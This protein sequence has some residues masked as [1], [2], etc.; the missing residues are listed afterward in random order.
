MTGRYHVGTWVI[1]EDA[2]GKRSRV[3][4]IGKACAMFYRETGNDPELCDMLAFLTEKQEVAFKTARRWWIIAADSVWRCYRR[5]EGND[6]KEARILY[7][8]DRR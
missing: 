7:Q 6:L 1:V 5:I 2:K 8:W 4:A 3:A